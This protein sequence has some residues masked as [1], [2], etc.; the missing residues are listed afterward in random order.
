MNRDKSKNKLFAVMTIMLLFASTMLVTIPLTGAISALTASESEG[1]VGDIITITGVAENVGATVSILW[2]DL[3][4]IALNTAKASAIDG[5]FN[6]DITIPVTHAGSYSIIA[7]EDLPGSSNYAATKSVQ[8]EVQPKIILE[9]NRGV[10]N[11]YFD[12]ICTGFAANTLIHFTF[13]TIDPF[14]ASHITDITSNDVGSAR[15]TFRVPTNLVDGTYDVTATGTDA[16][17]YLDNFDAIAEF[18]ISPVFTLTPK[19][20]PSGTIITIEGRGFT[21]SAIAKITFDGAVALAVVNSRSIISSDPSGTFTVDVVIPTLPFTSIGDITVTVDDGTKPSVNETFDLTGVT[22]ITVNPKVGQVSRPDIVGTLTTV[23]GQNFSTVSGTTANFRLRSI[24]TNE[25]YECGPQSNVNAAGRFT[26]TFTISGGAPNGAYM[27]NAYDSWGLYAE[28]PFA[29]IDKPIAIAPVTPVVTGQIITITGVGFNALEDTTLFTPSFRANFASPV[30]ANITINGVL[31]KMNVDLATLQSGDL[32]VVVP[33]TPV[34][35]QVVHITTN[36][37]GLNA[38]TT[39]NVVETTTV[40]VTPPNTITDRTITITGTYFSQVG[41]TANITIRASNNALV[42]D[43]TNIPIDS[44]GTFT[45]TWHVPNGTAIGTYSVWATDNNS[46]TRLQAQTTFNIVPLV[47][48]IKTDADGYTRGSGNTGSFDLSSTTPINIAIAIVDPNGNPQKLIEFTE[49]GWL[50]NAKTN[51][52]TYPSLGGINTIGPFPQGA[53]IG[54]W[55]WTAS[56]YDGNELKTLS[57][58]FEVLNVTSD[59]AGPA[60]L[61]SPQG[62]PGVQG[63]QG[64]QGIQGESGPKGDTGDRGATGATGSSGSG[65]GS[66]GPKGD[67]GPQGEPGATGA[68]AVVSN[69]NVVA[70]PTWATS[71]A[72]IAIVALIVG[73]VAAFLAITIRRR[74][75]S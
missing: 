55:T 49:S 51:N 15:G 75:A 3:D 43:L 41:A 18:T 56:Y 33:T 13:D 37:D 62:E 23:T 50:Y 21:P 16:K 27:L 68:P 36:I 67:T 61:A 70:A 32:E 26:T 47:V 45:E 9:S 19:Y 71:S 30:I 12:I 57:N 66:Q 65:S 20:G 31:A 4:T 59:S 54:P 25:I 10:P 69:E 72:I 63:I 11:D 38:E 39:I 5:T 73:A 28:Q 2:N 24:L 53:T 52:Y 14:R 46:P 58:T 7:R 34:G 17:L 35:Q 29:V 48:D 74:I 40:R 64:I 42:A 1:N 6:I 44:K 8:F 22:G 60:N